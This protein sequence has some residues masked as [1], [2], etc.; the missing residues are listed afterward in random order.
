MTL[1]HLVYIKKND[2]DDT[3]KILGKGAYGEVELAEIVK[4][5]GM[6]LLPPEII[7]LKIA[8][9]RIDKKSMRN[10]KIA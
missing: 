10:K 9:K 2:G 8:V 6:N 4:K 1:D 3:H 7:G 5:P